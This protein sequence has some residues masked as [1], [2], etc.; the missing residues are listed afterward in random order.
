M[1]LSGSKENTTDGE[2]L[3]VF[4]VCCFIKW[5]LIAY[6]LE[7]YVISDMSKKLK[8]LW[9]VIW[10]TG[11]HLQDKILFYNKGGKK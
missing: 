11:K 5:V 7:D 1:C 8:I 4:F 2:L 6:V 10:Y 3:V 9:T